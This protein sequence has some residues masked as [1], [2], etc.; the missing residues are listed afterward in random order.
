[1]N[2]KDLEATLVLE[3]YKEYTYFGW[4]FVNDTVIRHEKSFATFHI[5][6]RDTCSDNYSE[7]KKLETKYFDLKSSLRKKQKVDGLAVFF[8]FLLFIIPGIVY[9]IYSSINKRTIAAHNQKIQDQMTQIL[10]ECRQFNR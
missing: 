5:L 3:D 1:M 7:L 6:V 4:S 2:I 9:C 10:N 8:L